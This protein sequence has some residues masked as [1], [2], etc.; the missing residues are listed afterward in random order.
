MDRDGSRQTR[1]LTPERVPLTLPLAGIGE[2]AIATLVD[3]ILLLLFGIALLFLYTVWGRGDLEADVRDASRSLLVVAGVVFIV[4]IVGYD[5]FF[6]LAF[7][8]RTPGKRIARVRVID[9]SGR[10]PDLVTS[11]LRNGM[12]LVDLIPIGYGVGAIVMF[13]TGTRRLGDLVAGTVVVNERSRGIRAIDEVKRTAAGLWVAAPAWSDAEVQSAVDVIQRTQG[14]E[15]VAADGPCRR[16]LA[17]LPGPVPGPVAGDAPPRQLLAAAVMALADN[18]AGLAARLRRLADVEDELHDAIVAFEAGLAA[19]DT[20]DAVSRRA[21]SELML[22]TRREVPGRH[23]EALSMVLLDLERRRRL[24]PGPA[25]PRLI[26]YFKVDVP[27]TVWSERTQIARSAVIFAFA[28]AVGFVVSLADADVARALVGDDLAE[29]IEKGANWTDEIERQQS[30]GSTSAGIIINNVM[31]GVRVFALGVV[32]GVGSLIMLF[33]NGLS[34]GA[35]FGYATALGTQET[36]LRF[37]VA[38]GPVELSM[39]CVAAAAGLCL[40]RAVL[41]PGRRTRARALREE[42]KKGLHLAAF[43]TVGFCVVGTVEGFVSPGAHFPTA[44][45][46]TVGVVLWLLFAAWALTGRGT[47]RQTSS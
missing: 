2:R 29:R 46:A 38:H 44:L 39:V 5:V 26:R 13:F 25:L 42:G 7:A 11:L 17:R 40:G 14:L 34:L 18:N 21:S 20:V 37:I 45:N 41:S 6:D 12:R 10:T 24:R 22:A 4:S 33:V 19:A 31:V 1:V 47:E 30:Y 32:G 27:T 3:A 23:L 28:I 16:V 9:A 15:S 43:A 8:G 35:V 36:L